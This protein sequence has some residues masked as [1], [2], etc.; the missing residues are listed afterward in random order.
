MLCSR[1]KEL[2]EMDM[3]ENTIPAR[4]KEKKKGSAKKNERARKRSSSVLDSTNGE[5]CPIKF[6]TCLNL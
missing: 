6:S 5:T 3:Q 4:G 1:G 2:R